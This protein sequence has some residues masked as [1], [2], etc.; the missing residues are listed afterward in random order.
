[1]GKQFLLENNTGFLRQ[2]SHSLGKIDSFNFLIETEDIPTGSTGKA[3]CNSLIWRYE[4]ARVCIVMKGTYTDKVP[5]LLLQLA[6]RTDEL[7]NRKP[8]LDLADRIHRGGKA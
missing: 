1:M 6:V 8:H 4:E 5:P 7:F 2:F 3:I